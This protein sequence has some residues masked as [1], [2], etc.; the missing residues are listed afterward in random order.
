MRQTLQSPDLNLICRRADDFR[1]PHI[2]DTILKNIAQSEYLVADL[3]GANPN[4]FYELGI[5][6]CVKDAPKVILLAQSMDF[7]PFDLRHLRC[8]IYQQSGEGLEALR[9]EL[10]ATFQEASKDAFRFIARERTRFAFGKKL[11]G[12]ENNLFTITV[13]CPHV[14]LDAVKLLLHFERFSVDQPSGP[15][16][17]Q[18]LFLSEDRRSAAVENI[19]WEL[20]LIELRQD[21]ALLSLEKAR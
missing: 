15:L 16:E 11:V 20:H 19:P 13:E 1:T 3:T 10:V 9:S 7:V 2:L 21:E 5:A 8:I 14:G 6:H 17:S 12:A 18:F 4:V